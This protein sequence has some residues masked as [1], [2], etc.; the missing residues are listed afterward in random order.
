MAGHMSDVRCIGGSVWFIT[1]WRFFTEEVV[2][3]H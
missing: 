2:A 3:I 1:L